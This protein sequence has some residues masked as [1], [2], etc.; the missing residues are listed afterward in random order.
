MKKLLTAILGLALLMAASFPPSAMASGC[1]VG[2][3]QACTLGPQRT[4]LYC[5]DVEQTAYCTALVSSMTAVAGYASGHMN[6]VQ[7][8]GLCEF[9][10]H[11]FDCD[12]SPLSFYRS[13]NVAASG[14]IGAN[15][16][17]GSTP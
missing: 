2:V 4:G 10:C 1:F 9:T 17:N 11:Y 14:P 15:C 13:H 16:V 5:N 3:P 8:T 6:S 12:G 7:W